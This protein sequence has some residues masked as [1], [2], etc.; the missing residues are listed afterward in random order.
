M[1]NSRATS[2]TT[3]VPS[4]GEADSRNAGKARAA[5][6][7]GVLAYFVDQFDIYLPVVSLAP[8]TAYF[9]STHVDAGTAAILSAMIFASTLFGRPVGSMIFGHFADTI[10]RRKSTLVA[11][12]GFGITTALIAAM[13]GYAT[14][15]IGSVSLLIALRFIDGIFLGGEYTTAVPLAMEWTRKRRRGIVS[16]TIT[17]TSPGAYAVIAAITLLLLSVMPSAGVNSAYAQWGWRIPFIIGACLAVVLFRSYLKE[18]EDPQTTR[19]HRGAS[20]LKA[21]LSGPHRRSLA[22]VFVLMTGLWLATNSTIVV[23]PTLLKSHVGMPNQQATI[24]MLVASAIAAATYPLLGALSQRIGRRRFYIGWGLLMSTAGVTTYGLGVAPVGN[25]ATTVVL[26]TIATII[27]IGTYGPIA[28]YL[29]ERFPTEIRATG[30]GV[31]YSLS[32]IIPG[33][34]AFYLDG[35]G[36]IMPSYYAPLVLV[37]VAGL[38][39]TIGALLGPETKGVDMHAD[40]AS[41]PRFA[42]ADTAG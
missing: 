32:I 8:A 5:I 22:Q 3:P 38:L 34:Y 36:S 29:T 33:F 10:G 15:G 6:R 31:G 9:E 26:C 25:T 42:A 19:Q 17:C 30:Y 23:L 35:I 2:G 24:V 18:V 37:G 11:V 39:I 40:S 13:P 27:G 41:L 21:L 1:K 20:P 12:A 4:A 16:G 14:L 7:A 28:A